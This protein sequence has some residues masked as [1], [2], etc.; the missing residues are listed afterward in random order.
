MLNIIQRAP[1]MAFTSTKVGA[2]RIV[3]PTY[4]SKHIK[5][6]TGGTP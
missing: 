3:G 6:I 4:L 5:V 1:L 2:N